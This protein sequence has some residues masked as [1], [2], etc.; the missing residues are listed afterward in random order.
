MRLR[1][2]QR[3][4]PKEESV[5]FNA[6]EMLLYLDFNG[7]FDIFRPSN[8]FNETWKPPFGRVI[9]PLTLYNDINYNNPSNMILGCGILFNL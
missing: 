8:T 9:S 2:Y 7:G 3:C 6:N 5:S 1:D 4:L